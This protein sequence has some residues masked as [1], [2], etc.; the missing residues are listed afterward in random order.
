MILQEHLASYVSAWCWAPIGVPQEEKVT[1]VSN[2]SQIAGKWEWYAIEALCPWKM[3]LWQEV[4]APLH[5]TT[6][7]FKSLCDLF[8]VFLILLLQSGSDTLCLCLEYNP[9]VV[10]GAAHKAFPGGSS[11]QNTIS[12]GTSG[13]NYQ[14]LHFCYV[15]VL[16]LS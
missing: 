9:P 11:P 12:T 10:Q 15:P 13:R 16:W 14:L 3:R 7:F 5:R 2:L 6:T 4:M 1:S 8:S